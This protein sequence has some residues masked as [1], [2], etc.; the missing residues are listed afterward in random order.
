M[1]SPSVADAAMSLGA[2]IG[3]YF[4]VV[5]M[6]PSLFLVVWTTALVA[7]DAWRSEPGPGLL[8]RRLGDS[9]R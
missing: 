6:V 8:G 2:R 3:R 4:S 1:T 5:S 7:S 9:V